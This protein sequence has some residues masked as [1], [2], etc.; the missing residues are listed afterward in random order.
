MNEGWLERG[1]GA[2]AMTRLIDVALRIRSWR[3]FYG[4]K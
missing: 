2:T 3:F 1:K 4:E